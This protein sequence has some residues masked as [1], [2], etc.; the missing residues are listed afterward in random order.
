MIIS[1]AQVSW[2]I[3]PQVLNQNARANSLLRIA[4]HP[5]SFRGLHFAVSLSATKRLGTRLS[6]HVKFM[7]IMIIINLI[8]LGSHVMRPLTDSDL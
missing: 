1:S 5:T 6:Q 2:F 4:F 8:H 7:I 3:F